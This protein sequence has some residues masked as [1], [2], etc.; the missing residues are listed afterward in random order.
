MIR[1]LLKNTSGQGMVEYGLIIAL[2][3]LVI[4]G[5]IVALGGGLGHSI[6]QTTNAINGAA[7]H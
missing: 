2:I 5:T 4:I 3:T 6:T 7:G 1:G